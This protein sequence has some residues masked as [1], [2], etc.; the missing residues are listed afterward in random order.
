M[1]N[2]VGF[3][4]IKAGNNKC[5]QDLIMS[6]FSASSLLHFINIFVV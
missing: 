4:I 6:F 2:F 5:N 1:I 3:M